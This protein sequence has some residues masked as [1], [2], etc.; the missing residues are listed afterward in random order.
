MR[1]IIFLFVLLSSSLSFAQPGVAPQK[2]VGG[3]MSYIHTV[4][5]G[6][7]LWGL[8]QMYGVKVE[9]IMS[10]NSN[11]NEGLSVGQKI[12]IP[13]PNYVK[14]LPE[15]SKYKV[16]KGETLYGLSR[17]FN[18][19]VDELIKINPELSKGLK[20][21]QLI[22]VPGKIESE[23]AEEIEPEIIDEP[24]PNPF[25]A[26]TILETQETVTVSFSDSIVRHNVMSHE[27][28]YSISKRFMVSIEKIME[29]NKLS[30]TRLSEGQVLVI[31]V[32]SERI[33]KV[34]VKPVPD[35]YE[36]D[37]N[38]PLIF[39]IK[40]RYKIAVILPLHLDYGP[41]YSKYV[42]SVATQ[43]YMGALMALDSLK[44]MG[45]NADVHFFDSKN[46]SAAVQALV[47]GSEFLDVD[48]V[49]GPFFSK[50]QAIVAEYCKNNKIRMVCPV[51]SESKLLEKN[52][53]VYASVPSN[54][55]L[56]TG[57]AQYVL[58]THAKDKIILVKSTDKD[59][60][61]LYEAFR[62]SFNESPMLGEIRPALRETTIDGMKSYLDR[63]SKN[64]IIIPTLDKT[65]GVRFMNTLNRSSFKAKPDEIYV[66]GMKEWVDFTDI[67]NIYKNKFNLH[68]G[69]PNFVDYY[70]DE[71]IELNRTFRR[72]YNTDMSKM[73]V[74]AYDVFLFYCSN[75]F[76]ENQ[77]PNLMM[78]NFRMEQFSESDGYENQNVFIV[79]QEEYEL[80][81]SENPIND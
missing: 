10:N 26:D 66:F 11:L 79:E 46:D 9:D 69:S 65:T 78:N 74:Q 75:F 42:S 38:E 64:I 80:R 54:I 23:I 62:K 76:L 30:T 27:T 70:T 71:M 43:F 63:S 48:L 81:D 31:P 61:P 13:V 67:N 7:T 60:L 39:E 18:T 37:D 35:V 22:Q 2:E 77:K 16:K 8:Q 50:T 56:V 41:G 47:N 53:L 14:P 5:P 59:D 12:I 49:I 21:G 52:R 1:T 20:K 33:T 36:P 25:V 29:I 32:K 17:K 6:N 68:F 3:V 19:T 4:E 72:E 44:A 28:M 15:T 24:V 40:E 45:L 73:A 51:S 55:T 34:P 57:L 58:R